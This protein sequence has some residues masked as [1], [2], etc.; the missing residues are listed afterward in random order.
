[1]GLSSVWIPLALPQLPD[2]TPG[3]VPP[4]FFLHPPGFLGWVRSR[5]LPP[6]LPPTLYP[7]LLAH[8]SAFSRKCF[9]H[10]KCLRR[11]A[12]DV[13]LAVRLVTLPGRPVGGLP[14]LREHLDLSYGIC[15]CVH[16]F[17]D[18]ASGRSS[19]GP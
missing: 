19:E 13:G 12:G 9:T 11:G 8:S 18:M 6:R 1:M 2:P 4:I 5:L 3:E 17:R 15:S 16:V 7:F 14:G 10:G